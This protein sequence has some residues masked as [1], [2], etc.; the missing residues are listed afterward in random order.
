[1]KYMTAIILV[2]VATSIGGSGINSN[3]P[4]DRSGFVK[5][6]CENETNLVHSR[7]GRILRSSS[8]ALGICQ[9][10]PDTADFMKCGDI[11]VKNENIKCASKYVNYIYNKRCSGRFDT[12]KCIA[13][14]YHDG[15]NA[16][17][18]SKAAKIYIARLER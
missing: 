6:I 1:M 17:K 2:F 8:G 13:W 12:E 4:F 10:K 7:N 18:M 16:R 15:H 14:H 5:R 11:L 9:I 3:D